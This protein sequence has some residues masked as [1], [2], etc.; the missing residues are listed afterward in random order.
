VAEAKEASRSK[1]KKIKFWCI[2]QAISVS[3]IFTKLR[4][5]RY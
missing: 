3:L 1:R 2:W 4:Q 5:L